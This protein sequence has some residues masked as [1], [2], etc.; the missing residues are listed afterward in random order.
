M[1]MG[2]VDSDVTGLQGINDVPISVVSSKNFQF[3]TS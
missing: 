1:K 2:P 3:V